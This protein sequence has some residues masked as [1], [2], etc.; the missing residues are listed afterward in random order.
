[1]RVSGLS[2]LMPGGAIGKFVIAREL[3]RGG[4][5]IV[6]LAVDTLLQRR[7]A[8]KVV[9]DDFA[10]DSRFFDR[11]R[12][13]ARA[14]AQ[15]SHP[16]II[17]VYGLHDIDSTIAIESEYAAGGSMLGR[18]AASGA[19]VVGTMHSVGQ[20]L[21]ALAVCHR[22]GVVHRDIKPSN[23]LFDHHGN[24]KL[25]DFGLA[26]AYDDWAARTFAESNSS[27]VWATPRYAPPEAWEDEG[28]SP[29]WDVFSTGV[30]LYEQLGGRMPWDARQ[31]MA[32]IHRMATEPIIELR[33][34]N[35]QVSPEL[36]DAVSRMLA[37]SRADRPAD[38]EEVLQLLGRCPEY[39]TA[40]ADFVSAATSR[41]SV[42][43]K[44]RPKRMRARFAAAVT[45]LALALSGAWSLWGGGNDNLPQATAS[46]TVST[47]A[48]TES[49]LID[50]WL[51]SV[52]DEQST[53]YGVATLGDQ[54][55]GASGYW[56]VRHADGG[57]LNVIGYSERG[58]LSWSGTKS[59][60]GS[61]VGSGQW[62]VYQDHVGSVLRTGR[63]EGE[64]RHIQD[65]VISLSGVF[66]ADQTDA[67]WPVTFVAT[68]ESNV[69][70]ARFIHSMESAPAVQA[71]LFNDLAPRGNTMLTAFSPLLG[72][73]KPGGLRVRDVS[74]TYTI[75]GKLD[76]PCWLNVS[77]AL[78]DEG[79][80]ALDG[81]RTSG[82]F[83]MPLVDD[84]HVILGARVPRMATDA[85]AWRIGV[86]VVTQ[87]AIP[88]TRSERFFVQVDSTG[89]K[90]HEYWVDGEL[91]PI[92]LAWEGQTVVDGEF[93]SAELRIPVSA[94]AS[95]AS[96]LPLRVAV[97]WQ[98]LDE[99]GAAEPFAWFGYPDPNAPWHGLPLN[100]TMDP[101]SGV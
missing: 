47:V 91:H 98:T 23:I 12:H 76:E 70:P 19:D 75:D 86:A 37:I 25:A 39:A 93:Y 66:V 88:I 53:V 4:M 50:A 67:R 99:H 33:E 92:D 56:L 89:K 38:A 84:G 80:A 64:A 65:S 40:G 32:L 79:F 83:L 58:L 31:P 96:H 63:F 22:Q 21:G 61:F 8:L 100:R 18:A 13:E 3:G 30:E 2:R 69:T 77:P 60:S 15:L 62:A 36:S 78:I 48:E 72:A 57:Q 85:A 74:G 73:A 17:H 20:V 1:M 16:N 24:V 43:L 11:L 82:A 81:A 90:T 7:V 29:A 14:V 54:D 51:D 42:G 6:Y 44:A 97:V 55:P 26:H 35:S 9:R 28:P 5:G 71:L 52:K 41:H 68:R 94:L 27:C 45:V 101:A 34:L 87:Y 46:D 10:E 49:T 95:D 59:N